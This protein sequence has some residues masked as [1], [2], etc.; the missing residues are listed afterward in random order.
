MNLIPGFYVPSSLDRNTPQPS[1]HLPSWPP[2]SS[3]LLTLPKDFPMILWSTYFPTLIKTAPTRTLPKYSS[4]FPPAT[5]RPMP[6]TSLLSQE[7]PY[8]I[9][10][11]LGFPM[12]IKPFPSAHNLFSLF[13]RYS[14]ESLSSLDQPPAVPWVLWPH[15]FLRT[16][17]TH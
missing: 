6:H 9:W 16:S 14:R 13:P 8:F 7:L 17:A 3:G 4:Y 10:K 12:R 5:P 11:P 1:L 2:T 15:T